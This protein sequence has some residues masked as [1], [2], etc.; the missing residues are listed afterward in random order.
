MQCSYFPFFGNIYI[1]SQINTNLCPLNVISSFTTALFINIKC[2]TLRSI[3][4]AVAFIIVVA[5]SATIYECP[6]VKIIVHAYRFYVGIEHTL[7]SVN[8]RN[9]ETEWVIAYAVG[10]WEAQ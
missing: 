9:S 5:A 7:S 6:S 3:A 4:S 10:Q 1:Q 8:S 2:N